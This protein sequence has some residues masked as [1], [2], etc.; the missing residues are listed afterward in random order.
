[1]IKRLKDELLSSKRTFF[2]ILTC[3]CT[4]L[5]NLWYYLAYARSPLI[6]FSIL[7]VVFWIAFD[8]SEHEHEPVKG[9]WVWVSLLIAS[10]IIAIIFPLF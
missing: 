2:S 3:F 8:G 4:V 6:L 7:P 1:M 9:Y 5:I 10:T